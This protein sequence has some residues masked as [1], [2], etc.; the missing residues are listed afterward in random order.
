MATMRFWR[1]EKEQE[2]AERMLDKLLL[3]HDDKTRLEDI[4]TF[5]ASLVGQ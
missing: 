2:F 3:V 5:Y 1:N 4:K